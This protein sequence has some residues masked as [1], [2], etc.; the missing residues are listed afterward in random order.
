MIYRMLCPTHNKKLEPIPVGEE[1]GKTCHV[2]GRDATHYCK[3]C[4]Y[5]QCAE[6]RICSTKHHLIKIVEL[7]V[8]DACLRRSRPNTTTTGTPATGAA[9]PRPWTTMA[10]GIA[11]SVTTTCASSA[12]SDFPALPSL[13]I[14]T[15]PI[16]PYQSLSIL[17]HYT[18]SIVAIQQV[19]NHLPLLFPTLN[20]YPFF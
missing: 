14:L 8:L 6:C 18:D 3:S 2:C 20:L 9:S 12:L 4:K 19:L 17:I 5:V 7:N 16:Y 1:E 15:I 11:I 10:S 13:C